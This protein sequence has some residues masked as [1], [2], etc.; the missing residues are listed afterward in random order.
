MATAL[1]ALLAWQTVRLYR[2]LAPMS[3]DVASLA[4][5]LTLAPILVSTQYTTA[6]TVL[7][8]NL[9]VSLVLAALL[10]VL[11]ESAE[12]GGWRLFGGAL[13]V[14]ASVLLSEYGIAAAVAA[15]A[16]L[17]VCRRPRAAGACVLGA[18]AGYAL[19]RATADLSVR[20]KQSPSAQLGTLLGHPQV[21]VLRFFEG[22]W[23][24]FAGAWAGAAGTIRFSLYDRSTLLAALVGMGAAAVLFSEARRNPTEPAGRYEGRAGFALVAAVA[25]GILPVVLANR[26][27]TSSDPYESRYL[28]PVLPFAAAALTLGLVRITSPRA[29]SVVLAAVAFV[30]AYRVVAGAFE[31]RQ[32]QQRMEE[33]GSLLR[34]LVRDSDGITVAVVPDKWKLDGSDM[35]PKVTWKWS[36]ADARRVWVMPA[37]RAAEEFGA[38]GGCHGTE[39]IALAP[40]L[41]STPRV[42]ALSHFVWLSAW[43]RTIGELEPY[44]L[45]PVR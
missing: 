40:E 45:G 15:V 26:S 11:T 2:R 20:V 31:T 16:L 36:D 39:K 7:P 27:L 8:A 25:A 10:L 24:C 4:G 30:A 29:R 1:W 9:P 28:L 5:L 33:V 14:A 3:S 35:T 42:G 44:C 13:L 23:T 17:W 6:T 43:G 34:P 21:A 19:F 18:A 38:R 32:E 41:M 22:L 37:N 12:P